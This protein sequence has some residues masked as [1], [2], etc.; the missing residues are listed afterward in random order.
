MLSFCLKPL[1]TLL[2]IYNTKSLGK[3]VVTTVPSGSHDHNQQSHE[4]S[5]ISIPASELTWKKSPGISGTHMLVFKCRPLKTHVPKATINE[6]PAPV[7]QP[8][9]KPNQPDH[10]TESTLSNG[11]NGI[12]TKETDSIFTH[13]S[14]NCF[15][16]KGTNGVNLHDNHRSTLNGCTTTFAHMD[17]SN[18]P[19]F[20]K[21][22][23]SYKI[24]KNRLKMKNNHHKKKNK[25]RSA[26][27]LLI[28]ESR[29]FRN[30][31]QPMSED[32][33]SRDSFADDSNLDEDEEIEFSKNYIV[34]HSY[35]KTANGEW[36]EPSAKR[37]RMM[38][39]HE[40]L[41]MLRGVCSAELVVFDSRNKCLLQDG[42]YE[43]V[44]QDCDLPSSPPVGSPLS[45]DTIFGNNNLVSASFVFYYLNCYRKVIILWCMLTYRVCCTLMLIYI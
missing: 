3:C 37:P 12:D 36:E 14:E 27:D 7:L 42:Q 43:L 13:T 10:E 16:K 9:L 6:T 24:F 20:C 18:Y 19:P 4:T 29:Q 15:V 38:A 17:I 35:A 26:L 28:A 2:P 22:M 23:E 44:L 30:N 40:P 1:N 31:T 34:D 41:E 45:W 25:R 11:C 5:K 33:S 32:E 8:D 39:D 21:E